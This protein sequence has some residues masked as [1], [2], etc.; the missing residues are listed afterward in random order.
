MSSAMS[1]GSM[2]GSAAVSSVVEDRGVYT[3]SCGYCGGRSSSVA[4]GMAA[5]ALTVEDYQGL[6]DRGW[7]RSG[8][9]LYKPDLKVTCCRQYAI[10]LPVTEFSTSKEQRRVINR[11][12]KYLEGTW[13]P[14]ETS[15]A[16][17]EM[18]I[19]RVESSAHASSSSR[20]FMETQLE[21][22]LRRVLLSLIDEG[23]LPS[24]LRI[25][26][27][28]SWHDRI[29]AKPVKADIAAR[30]GLPADRTFSCN[31][32]FVISAAVKKVSAAQAVSAVA[33]ADLIANR[34]VGSH[35]FTAHAA[36]GHLNLTLH[37]LPEADLFEATGLEATNGEV[38][39]PMESRHTSPPEGTKH[40]LEITTTRSVFT[41]EEFELYRKYQMAVHQDK[42]VSKAQYQQFLIDS[43]LTP[44][45][46]GNAGAECFFLIQT[47]DCGFGSFHQQYRID[48]KCLSSVY[49]FW[50]PDYAFLSPGKLAAIKEIEFVQ[51]AR[52]KCPSL[53]Y[54]YLGYYIH[55]CPKMRYKA[56]YSPSYLLC[57][58]KYTWIP[59]GKVSKALDSQPYC[60]LSEVGQSEDQQQSSAR[61]PRVF[62][63]P[64]A[65]SSGEST[66][67]S[68]SVKKGKM[69]QQRSL[70]NPVSVDDVPLL[71][72]GHVLPFKALQAMN[73]L[74][75]AIMGEIKA[76][77]E[78]YASVVGPQLALNL[79]YRLA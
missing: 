49:V 61:S 1:S 22:Q 20:S 57:P 39:E 79:T 65:S 23:L 48:G 14:T 4:H 33:V 76:E 3:S 9:W 16:D 21:V 59:L 15:A 63:E 77:L 42:H 37:E 10:R 55:T 51:S 60:A 73:K 11:L 35:E 18:P 69:D 26:P 28:S 46:E 5:Q 38:T 34:V 25:E 53:Q 75:R 54:Y 27:V 52:L 70:Q 30:L 72:H 2:A 50:D 47:P 13:Q 40:T 74:P 12:N 36:N 43:P 71:L 6:I 78:A 45:T 32:G 41:Q 68:A 24:A 17:I 19:P 62:F 56:G 66:L 67:G 7:R 29:S 44:V 8:T 31:A 58:V 64:V